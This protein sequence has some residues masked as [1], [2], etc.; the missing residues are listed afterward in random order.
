MKIE[1][2]NEDPEP[3]RKLLREWPVNTPLPPRFQEQVWQRIEKAST[4]D[5]PVFWPAF[6]KWLVSVTTRPA[7]ALAYATVLLF[8]GLGAGYWHA[9]ET[10]ANWDKALAQRYVQAIDLFQ[11]TARN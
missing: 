5:E 11:Q 3:V 2:L 10:T 1:Q 9:R 6:L 4:R 7:L 8:A